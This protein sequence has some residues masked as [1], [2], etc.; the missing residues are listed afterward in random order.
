MLQQ[1]G[2]QIFTTLDLELQ[3]KAETAIA[4]NVPFSDSRFDVG[5]VAVTVQPGTG[6]I[7]AMAQ[8]KKYSN[9]PDVVA[10]SPEYTSVNYSTDYEYGGSSGLQP[11]STYK[12]FTLAEW[13]KRV[14]P[15]RRRSTARAARSRRSPT[16]APATTRGRPTTRA[17]TTA[18]SRTTPSTRPR[19]R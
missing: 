14:I 3:N 9:D 1:G 7:L 8:N 16:A 18:E 11:G 4:E 6:R 12:V 19:G 2:L 15:S 5:S 10:T 13:L 17:T